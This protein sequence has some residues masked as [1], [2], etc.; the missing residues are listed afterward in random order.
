MDNKTLMNKIAQLES[1]N[2]HLK[3]ELDYVDAL[4]RMVGFKDGLETVKATANELIRRGLTENIE[5]K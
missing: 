4:M 2:D 5:Y 1:I 3:T